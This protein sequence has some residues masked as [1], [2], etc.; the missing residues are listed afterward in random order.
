M[1][2]EMAVTQCV[3]APHLVRRA[4]VQEVGR[5]LLFRQGAAGLGDAPHGGKWE[6]PHSI[7]FGCSSPQIEE[8]RIMPLLPAITLRQEHQLVA[9]PAVLTQSALAAGLG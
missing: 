8:F 7:I 4:L 1:Y 3:N 6:G 5:Q 2:G 9:A